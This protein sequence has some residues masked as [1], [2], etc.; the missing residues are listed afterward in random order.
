MNRLHP[1]GG[2]WSKPAVVEPLAVLL[3]SKW[4]DDSWSAI[5]TE[6]DRGSGA[7]WRR[8]SAAPKQHPKAKP[9]M[10]KS[11]A[12]SKTEVVLHPV[13][14]QACGGGHLVVDWVLASV[15]LVVQWQCTS[16]HCTAGAGGQC[17]T[18]AHAGQVGA[19]ER[20]PK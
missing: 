3:G 4:S 11:K 12:T 9:M 10:R 16:E 6:A 7:E 18:G 8:R 2:N 20:A 13:G 19:P 17:N 14:P 15:P 1:M 5:A